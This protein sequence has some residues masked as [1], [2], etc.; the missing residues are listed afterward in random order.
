MLLGKYAVGQ[1]IAQTL[2]AVS[3]AGEHP[4]IVLQSCNCSH[5][6]VCRVFS[7]VPYPSAL[8]LAGWKHRLLF[9]LFSVTL[10][11]FKIDTV[12]RVK[13]TFLWTQSS[14]TDLRP[15]FVNNVWTRCCKIYRACV[16]RLVSFPKHINTLPDL[17]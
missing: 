16:T 14:T 15:L 8:A 6:A 4:S 3:W 17:W 10:H 5:Y 2:Q 7:F 1:R 11:I 13:R 9:S 12:N